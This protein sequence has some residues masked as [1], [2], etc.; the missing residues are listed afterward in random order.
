M[1]FSLLGPIRV[2]GEDGAEMAVRGKLRRTLLAELLL[3][4]GSVVSA[5]HLAE[6]LWASDAAGGRGA[7][8]HNQ[9]ARLRQDL[10]DAGAQR[11]KAVPPGYLV[12]VSADELDLRQFAAHAATGR[13]AAARGDWAEASAGYAAALALWR[14][15]PLADLPALAA[16]PVVQR[17]DEE[18]WTALQGRIEADLN[19]GRHV[20]AA[21][22]LRAL[23]RDQPLREPLHAQLMLAL[24]QDGR[25]DEALEV[26]RALSRTLADE[27]GLEP[28]ADLRELHERI[29]REDST[30]LIRG[31]GPT[32]ST[33]A[34]PAGARNQLPVDTRLFTGREQESE[35][36]LALAREA[37]EG[38]RSG[39]L[40][41]SALDGLGGVGKSALAVRIAHRVSGLFPD[42]QLFIDLHGNV[43]H[44]E[45]LTPLAALGQLLRS[46]DV[47]QQQIPAELADCSAM[48]R[49]RLGGTK[50]LI[51]LDNAAAD[52]QVRPLL[53]DVPGCLVL[54]TSRARLAIEGALSLRLDVLSE[55]EA[56]ALLLAAAGPGRLRPDDPAVAELAEL[57]GRI[58]LA[59]RI[60]A[61]RLRHRRTLSPSGLADQ[62]RDE[63]GR[64]GEL[65]DEDRDLADVL[66]TSYADLHD[67]E[68]RAFRLLGLVPGA[69]VDE[70]A[71]AALLGLDP[72]GTQHLFDLLFDRNLLMEATPGRYRMHDLVR[73]FAAGQAQTPEHEAEREQALDRLLLWY[74]ETTDTAWR[75]VQSDG[76]RAASSTADGPVA[77]M[78]FPSGEDGLAWYDR[79]AGNLLA[80]SEF[81]RAAGRAAPGLRLTSAMSGLLQRRGDVRRWLEAAES[82]IRFAREVGDLK[83][84]SSLV[85]TKAAALMHLGRNEESLAAAELALSLARE[86]G[87][88]RAEADMYVALS[89]T[90]ASAKHVDESI[91]AGNEA[92]TRY[93]RLGMP[94]RAAGGL[95]NMAAG[96]SYVG[97]DEEAL[98]L[99]EKAV[100]LSREAD[101]MYTLSACLANLAAITHSLGGYEPAALDATY[102]EAIETLHTIG[103]ARYEL[104]AL[105]G[106]GVFL[107]EARRHADA[108]RV[109]EDAERLGIALAEPIHAKARN[110]LASARA[111]VAAASSA[112]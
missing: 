111:A 68:Q 105:L 112:P 72:Q 86:A 16:D 47:P 4:V 26:F 1:R 29:S 89:A 13:R 106:Y 18:R 5:D 107:E 92:V 59:L 100:L 71:A 22:E 101:N 43:R 36:L 62:L 79:E 91:A 34:A 84:E 23:T 81:C 96:L 88:E 110:T 25:R 77:P 50:T 99:I 7:R 70:H 20:E 39:T 31:G 37:A 6:L 40:T 48:L 57:C 69:D 9:I 108:V 52:T 17:L 80:A 104:Q 21:A 33:P 98:P 54:I 76:A 55:A 28:G 93:E 30:L 65:R 66:G 103:N 38:G 56:V 75:M 60:I 2:T 63:R 94:D 49:E 74:A 61:A 53:P 97:R 109:L 3:N 24:Y 27:A 42:G 10:G 102:R 32:S 8:L 90:H 73:L 35:R 67:D 11:V 78:R 87:D 64:L 15:A 58:P 85:R 83:A 95:I 19:L 46:L 12:E 41:I 44:R 82:G 14:G 45:P 51:L